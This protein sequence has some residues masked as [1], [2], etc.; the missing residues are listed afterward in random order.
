MTVASMKLFPS[1]GEGVL[2]A[3]QELAAIEDDLTDVLGRI[4]HVH[5]YLDLA[6]GPGLEWIDPDCPRDCGL[7]PR[8]VDD[9][10][11]ITEA[12]RTALEDL[13]A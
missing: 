2:H 6:S 13:T 11:T 9:V 7:D 1:H 5:E 8:D 12:I 3:R 4:Q 10:L